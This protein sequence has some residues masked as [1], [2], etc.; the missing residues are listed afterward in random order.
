MI[1][2]TE[3]RNYILKTIPLIII[4]NDNIL[5]INYY[6]RLVVLGTSLF[7]DLPFPEVV[8][9]AYT[10]NEFLLHILCSTDIYKALL[11]CFESQI[12]A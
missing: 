1:L 2:I 4:I 8:K 5:I 9:G 11:T 7:P 10:N 6:I 12:T 3:R